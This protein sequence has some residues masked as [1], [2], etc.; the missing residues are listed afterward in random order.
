MTFIAGA[1]SATFGA[2]PIGTTEDGF[3]LSFNRIQEEIRIDQYRGLVDAVHQGADMSI[4]FVLTEANFAAIKNMV[5]SWSAVSP[6]VEGS[7]GSH[8]GKLISSFASALILTP[9]TGTSADVMTG[10]ITFPKVVL[11]TDPV[12][13]KFASSLRRVPI[14]LHVLPS[15]TVGDIPEGY[16][17][18]SY[19]PCGVT[20][21]Y[22]EV[23]A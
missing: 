15:W 12:A 20:M 14:T 13:I 16:P 4:R 5:W 21:K 3:E 8:A 1:F 23:A 22:Y 17:V 18:G 9:C 2:L 6:I 7:V 11:A 10:A 19:P